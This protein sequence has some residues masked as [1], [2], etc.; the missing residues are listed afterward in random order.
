M[1]TGPLRHAYLI[2]AHGNFQILEKQLRFLDSENADFFIHIDSK[3]ADFDFDRFRAIPKKSSVTFVD[4]VRISWGHHSQ[5]QSELILLKAALPGRYDYYH[6]LSGVDVP[7][8]T[9][10]YIENYFVSRQGTNFLHFHHE[11]IIRE[12]SDRVRYYYPLQR[13]NL[14]N[15]PFRLLLRRMCVLVQWPFVDRTKTFEPGTVFQKGANWFSITHALAEYVVS[16]ED[17]IKEHFTSTFCADEVFIH[18]LVVNSRFRDTLPEEYYGLDH[19][20]CL[21]YID[22]TR[23]K[24]YTFRDE[25]YEELIHTGEPYLFARK[26]DYGRYP[27]VVD[28]LFEHFGEGREAEA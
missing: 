19:K 26:F 8:K 7:V 12:Y 11:K 21:R 6:L 24:P 13:W 22:W 1:E 10:Q 9:R 18:T 3:V 16:K 23:G 15:R 27:G 5:I 25:D 20:N 17:W 14:M 2:I 28:R 4:R